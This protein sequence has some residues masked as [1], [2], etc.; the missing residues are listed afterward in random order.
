MIVL[1]GRDSKC[2]DRIGA[3]LVVVL[4][5]ASVQ[6]K[7]LAARGEGNEVLGDMRLNGAGIRTGFHRVDHLRLPMDSRQASRSSL[8][9]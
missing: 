4:V 6:Q 1:E 8:P 5:S 9:G 3:M 2:G 7:R